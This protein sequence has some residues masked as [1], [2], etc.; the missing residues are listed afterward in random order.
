MA[1]EIEVILGGPQGGGIETAAQIFI[2]SLA[3]AGYYVYG[4]R[5]YFSN[6]MGRHSYFQVRARDR[7]VRSVRSKV[8]IVAGLDAESIATHF[9]DIVDGGAIIYDPSF[10]N[11]KIV[12]MPMMEPDTKEHLIKRLKSEGYDPSVQ[13]ALMYAEEKLNAKL[14]P[15]PY[16]Q[17]LEEAA[18]KLNVQS[19]AIVQRFLNTVVLSAVAALIGLPREDLESGLK[20]VFGARKPKAVEQNLIVADIVYDYVKSNFSPFHKV[21]GGNKGDNARKEPMA[22]LNGNEAIAIGKI[23]GGL[24][25][26][27]YYPITPAADESF[28]LE[29]HEQLQIDPEFSEEAEILKGAGIVVFQAEDEMAAINMA[30]GA[31]LTGARAATATSGPGFSLMV[32]GLGWAGINEVPVVVTYYMR[33]GPSTGLPTRDSQSDLLF[34]LSAGHGEFPRIVLSSGDHE[35]AIYDAVKA[36]NWAERYQTPVIHLVEKNLANSWMMVKPPKRD[37]I[38]IDRGHLV[39]DENENKSYARFEF[40]DNGVSPRALI[41]VHKALVWY[42]GDEHDEYGH[43]TEDPV[44]RY[45]M[46]K[47]RLKKLELADKEIPES[48]RA[49]LYGDHDADIAIVGW[50]SVKGA[51]LDAMDSLQSRGYNVKFLQIKVFSPFPRNIVREVL[52]RSKIVIDIENN[53]LGQ[54]ARVIAMETGILIKHKALKWTG[55]PITE[56][57]VVMAVEKVVKEGAETV[58][59]RDGK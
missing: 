15:L 42:T 45:E 26:Q 8:D 51:V 11:T 22:I 32:E 48:E 35:E 31:A 24:T 36:L 46:Y 6:I 12:A 17:M 16:K 39:S 7:P 53:Y 28:F 50:G 33:G 20:D 40:Q 19:L 34:A 21:I 47:K 18:K 3:R 57:E 52:S 25:F 41:G 10:V 9:D 58:I 23:L 13:G 44:T 37:L 55:R 54:A 38:S 1:K 27:T 59:L 29:A 2:R 14:Y 30:T 49:I 5:E 4:K 43:I 56:S